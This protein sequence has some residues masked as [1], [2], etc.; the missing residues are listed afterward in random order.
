MLGI[1]C[2]TLHVKISEVWMGVGKLN[3]IRKFIREGDAQDLVEYTLILA[4]VALASAGL[5]MNAGGSVARI[6]GS[7]NTALHG[8]CP[9]GYVQDGGHEDGSPY[10]VGPHGDVL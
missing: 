7:A 4:F 3:Y 8:T 5:F 6:W 10:C 1:M 9:S 2:E